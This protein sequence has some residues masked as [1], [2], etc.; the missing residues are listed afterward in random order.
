MQNIQILDYGAGN[1]GSLCAA[2]EYIGYNVRLAQNAN[3]LNRRNPV[4]LP[5]VGSFPHAVERLKTLGLFEILR[6]M[7]EN[8]VPIFGICLGMQVLFEN[9]EEDEI[10]E[11]LGLIHGSVTKFDRSVQGIMVP[12]IGFNSIGRVSENKPEILRKIP[13]D[14]DYYFVHSFAVKKSNDNSSFAF[15]EN[16]EEFISVAQKDNLVGVQFHPEKSQSSGL[17]I[18]KNFMEM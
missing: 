17:K 16:G 12:H 5:G 3:G 18:L 4:I 9:S 6:E 13:E 15:T 10:T 14:I 8:Q 11:G 7:A 2:V 1:I